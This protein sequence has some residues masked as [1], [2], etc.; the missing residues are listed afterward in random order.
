MVRKWLP[1]NDILAHPNVVLFISHGM[2]NIF[3]LHLNIK[4]NFN[5]MIVSGGMFGFLE[6]LYNGVPLIM[7]PFFGDQHRNAVRAQNAGHAKF[8]KFNDITEEALFGLIHEMT[9]DPSYKQTSRET[10]A[11]FKKN[12]MHPLD[13]AV[14]WIEYVCEFRGA[15]HLKSNAIHMSWF[16]YLLID[17]LL[18][19]VISI[20]FGL[21]LIYLVLKMCCRKFTANSDKKKQK[22]N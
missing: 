19:T 6:S 2:V 10:S 13:E 11:I 5:F 4:M 3:Q 17:V 18:A 1:Q 12:L 8:I 21:I 9:T 15:K 16:S 7:I 22:I 20:S 14:W